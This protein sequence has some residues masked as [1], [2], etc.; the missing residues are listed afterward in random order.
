MALSNT[1][2]AGL[3]GLNVNQVKLN[4]VANNIAN[5]NTVAFKSTRV[6]FK[7]QFYVTDAGGTQPQ[8]PFGGT[9]PSQR[10]LGAEIAAL[11]KNFQPG[12]IEATGRATDL[13]ID[14]E[15]FFIVQ[16]DE[17]RYTRDG[18][19]KINSLNQ[20]VTNSGDIVQGFGVDKD[21][22]VI[23]GELTSIVIPLGAATTA[24]ATGNVRFEGN[25]NAGGDIAAGAS[26]LTTQ[27]LTTVGGLAPPAAG[28]LLTSIA[29]TTAPG[30]ALFTTGDVFNL[31][32]K[33]G[34]RDLAEAT[35]TVAA[36][37]TLNDLMTFFQQGMG[38]NTNVPDDGN[39]LTPTAGVAVEVDGTDP[40]SARIVLT[41]NMGTEN[42]LALSNGSFETSGG[43]SPFVFADGTNAAGIASDPIGES[44]H[45]SFVAYDSLG[46]P[47]TIGVTSVLESTSSTG[48][49]W[50]FFAE[51]ADDTD[52]DLVIGT[53]TLTFDSAGKLRDSTGTTV[54][55]NRNNTGADSPLNLA[56]DFSRLTELTSTNSELVMTNQ[57]GSP[58]GRLNGFSIGGDGKISGSFSN[59]ISR[60]LGQ[61]A[62]ATFSN[63][64]GLIDRGGNMFIEGPNS[65]AAVVGTAG[66]LGT[67]K[68]VSGS[69]EL[70]NVDLSEEFINLIIASTGFSAA[71][72]V[73]TTSDQLLTELLNTSR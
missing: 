33:K 5:V 37:S 42:A 50:R 48:N 9:N 45:T 16:S 60:T 21:F 8:D 56:L 46:T 17:R 43:I 32:G 35:F 11:E 34:G 25:L 62:L 39:P 15:G 36:T 4:V 64:Q 27:L 13:A 2:F 10:G 65:G 18:T 38:V 71:S 26:I 58:I 59:G 19:F 70:S 66:T 44:I 41:G 40:N 30:T 29:D 31:G 47:I 22:K 63:T 53:G 54:T 61:V 49:T 55:I 73:I 69:L 57:D 28:D 72:R 52:V 20:L 68:V 51:S 1:L 24:S 12:S 23:S 7:P 67:G 6:Q 14:G 3:S